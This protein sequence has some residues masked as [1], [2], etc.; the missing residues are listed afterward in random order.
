MIYCI[1][2]VALLAL[3]EID[4]REGFVLASLADFIKVFLQLLVHYFSVLLL[5]FRQIDDHGRIVP[6]LCFGLK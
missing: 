4:G 6:L 3:V 5:L 1:V 2:F